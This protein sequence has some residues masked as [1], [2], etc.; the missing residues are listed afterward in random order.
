MTLNIDLD[1]D[2]KM[3]PGKYNREAFIIYRSYI[4]SKQVVFWVL[5]KSKSP[6]IL[7]VCLDH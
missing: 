6:N 2:H 1:L 5:K 3:P 4:Y 7:G